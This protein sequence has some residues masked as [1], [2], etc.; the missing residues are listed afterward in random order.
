MAL[1]ETRPETEE[2]SATEGTRPTPGAVERLLGSGD[3]V[4][5]GRLYVGFAL[6]FA[7]LSLTLLAA[8]GVDVLTDNGF[9]GSRTAQL[10][11]SAQTGLLFL[12][13][14]PLL[15]GIAIAIVPLQLA[16]PAIAFPRAAALSFWTWLVAAGIFIT[17]VAID[18]GFL[19]E[20][21]TAAKLGNVSFGALLAALGLGAVCVAT[22][23]IAHRPLGMRL[24]YVPGLAWAAL[25]GAS[26]T[27]VTLGAGFA[28]VVL[29]QV[30]RMGATELATNFTDSL[31]WVFRG[32]T[33]FVF[34]VPVLG[35]AADVVATATGRRFGRPD[36]VQLVIGMYAVLAFGAWAQ[37]PTALNTAMWTL[38][39]VA[40]TVPVLAM[41]GALGDNL[42]RGAVAVTPALILS[43]VGVLL[44]L[45]AV[46]TG[47]IQALSLAGEGR[48]F[49]ASN[50]TL[51]AAQTA[52]V[53]AAAIA[54]GLAG[55]MHWAPLLW[56]GPARSP[57]SSLT[58]PL[59]V[60]GGGLL[61]TATLVQA[62]V[63]VDRAT[64]ASQVF[65]AL[66]ALGAVLFALGALSGLIAAIRIAGSSDDAPADEDGLTLE[67]S[68]PTPAAGG[69]GLPE[70]A[71]VG[72][73]Y[74][75][76]DARRGPDEEKV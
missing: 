75:L 21:A 29:G 30:G 7:T 23:V 53:A 65:G 25:V 33:V 18:G 42:R 40:V 45:G 19:G 24:A 51:A 71:R 20:D 31:I 10:A 62:V 22:T 34:A 5:I 11:A 14:V 49:G 27:I 39:A 41:L 54:G 12:G 13:V 37:M 32:P 9:L 28:H 3:H 46:V 66:E 16:S 17:S 6:A 48:L 68:F 60:G 1:T 15:L 56:G 50:V 43:I 26:V 36:A 76:L 70:L 67:W 74:P 61:A 64:T 73:P 57:E 63:Q 44:L 4:A 69:V 38:F 47:W 58:V 2:P 72:S 59:V 55:S 35:I 52:F 8:T